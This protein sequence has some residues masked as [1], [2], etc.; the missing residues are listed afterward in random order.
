MKKE[1]FWIKGQ[2]F[3]NSIVALLLLFS[4]LL[5]YIYPKHAPEFSI[6]SLFVPLLF[7]LNLFFVIYWIIKLKKYFLI[8]TVFI[9]LGI[10]YISSFYKFSEKKI[11]LN[12]DIKVM[13]YNVRMFNHY[14]WSSN[15]SIK[16][17]I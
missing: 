1:N 13:N 5:P 14:Q 6:I 9:L 11:F 12:E 4:Y 8:S 15:D 2:L 17:K 7:L 3:L 10:E 16:E